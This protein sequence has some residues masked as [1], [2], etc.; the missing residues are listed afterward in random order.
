MTIAG[1]DELT[2][3]AGSYERNNAP[4]AP[5]ALLPRLLSP[6]LPPPQHTAHQRRHALLTGLDPRDPPHSA[7]PHHRC[8]RPPRSAIPSRTPAATSAILLRPPRPTLPAGRD[9]APAPPT[10]AARPIRAVPPLPA[11]AAAPCNPIAASRR[12]PSLPHHHHQLPGNSSSL[13]RDQ[14]L[15]R[16]PPQTLAATARIDSRTL[17]ASIRDPIPPPVPHRTAR[18]RETDRVRFRDERGDRA[19]PYRSLPDPIPTPSISANPKRRL[20]NPAS[21]LARRYPRDR[22]PPPARAIAR[23]RVVVLRRGRRRRRRRR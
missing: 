5:P 23:S 2:L 21:P 15:R 9:R 12:R 7:A 13:I 19:R 10:R 1:N 11:A 14:A 18:S 6:L 22:D 3:E 4:P 8:P 17:T 20:P 16:P